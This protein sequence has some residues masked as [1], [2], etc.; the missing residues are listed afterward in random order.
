MNEKT[1]SQPSSSS[2][3]TVRNSWPEESSGTRE[4]SNNNYRGPKQE[5]IPDKDKWNLE[6][7]SITDKSLTHESS[8]GQRPSNDD[9]W[10]Q[11]STS[12]VGWGSRVPNEGP[13]PSNDNNWLQSSTAQEGWGHRVPNEG[14]RPSNDNNWST[15]QESWG[16]RV[17]NEGPRPSNDDNWLKSSTAQEGW[18]PRVHNE[19]DW[20]QASTSWETKPQVKDDWAKKQDPISNED[21]F[22]SNQVTDSKLEEN[23]E[24]KQSFIEDN[25][26]INDDDVIERSQ[27]PKDQEDNRVTKQGS[28][29]DDDDE[30]VTSGPPISSQVRENIIKQIPTPEDEWVTSQPST[31][32]HKDNQIIKQV[33]PQEEVEWVTSNPPTSFNDRDDQWKKQHFLHENN[34]WNK[35]RSAPSEDIRSHKKSDKDSWGGKGRS[36]GS[37]EKKNDVN[38]GSLK[39]AATRARSVD[40]HSK[41]FN[42]IDP[43]DMVE[44]DDLSEVIHNSFTTL[45]IKKH[46]ERKQFD[47]YDLNDNSNSAPPVTLQETDQTYLQDLILESNNKN[48]H[49]EQI[50]SSFTTNYQE[51]SGKTFHDVEVQTDPIDLTSLENYLN[52]IDPSIM[53][54]LRKELTSLLGIGSIRDI[55]NKLPTEVFSLK[56]TSSLSAIQTQN[57]LILDMEPNDINKFEPIKTYKP[58]T[59]SDTTFIKSQ[60]DF[61]TK[62][63]DPIVL[64]RDQNNT[65]TDEWKDT[66]TS[67]EWTSSAFQKDNKTFND[68][69]NNSTPKLPD[70][71][72]SKSQQE[73]SVKV[74][75]PSVIMRDQNNTKMDELKDT[76]SPLE[77]TPF[78]KDDK[79]FNEPW[80]NSTQKLP[81]ITFSK[82]QQDSSVKVNDLSIPARDQDNTKID[83]RRDIPSSHERTSHTF[84]KV[85]NG[86]WN[87]PSQKLSNNDSSGW[88]VQTDSITAKTT[89]SVK[90]LIE[91]DESKW[92]N[93]LNEPSQQALESWKVPHKKQVAKEEF[94]WNIPAKIPTQD[95]HKSVPESH[96]QPSHPITSIRRD[97][98]HDNSTD[99]TRRGGSSPRPFSNPMPP[100]FPPEEAWNKLLLADRGDDIE[101][102]KEAFEEYAKASPNE[103]FQTIEKKLRMEGC[104]G[105]I[106]ALK[107]EGIPL[108][109]CLI[110]LQ[111]NTNKKYLAQLITSPDRLSRA[112]GKASSEEENFQW[113][114][115]AGF[116]A[117][118]PTPVC[119]NCK[120]KG[121]KTNE[122]PEP[123]HENERNIPLACQHCGA[124]DHMTKL[125]KSDE[126]R[127]HYAEIRDQSI[128]SDRGY[129]YGPNNNMARDYNSDG[130]RSE[131]DY[132][133]RNFR[134]RG[135][136][137]HKCNRE[138]HISRDCPES[139]KDVR[140]CFKCGMTG[141]FERDCNIGNSYDG[142]GGGY[143]NDN[144]SSWK[145][146]STVQSNS[147][148]YNSKES[149][150]NKD[151]DY[152]APMR[153]TQDKNSD[154]LIDYDGNRS[155][156][157]GAKDEVNKSAS[158]VNNKKHDDE[159]KV[160]N[161]DDS[162]WLVTQN[163]ND[164]GVDDPWERAKKDA[165]AGWE[166]RPKVTT[167]AQV[168]TWD[169]P[170]NADF[171]NDVRPKL[172][173]Q[174]K[175]PAFGSSKV[176]APWGSQ[177]KAIN[178]NRPKWDTQ[179]K[180]SAFS[181]S[182]VDVPW[183][184]QEKATNYARPK[185]D[186]QGSTFSSSKGDAP[187]GSQ[188]KTT[189]DTRPTWGTHEKESTF[190]SSKV[191]APWGSQ[192]TNDTRP[193]WDT[194]EK[195]S[196]FSSSKVDPP[197]GSQTTNDA[198]P[199]WDAQG[200]TSSSSKD[201]VPRGSQANNDA[202]PKLDTQEIGSTFS[203]SK[204]DAQWGSQTTYDARPKWDMQEKVSTFSSSKV[205]APWGSQ[206]T[207]DTRP[208]WGTQEKGPTFSSKADAPW[209]SQTT[210]DIR[211]KWDAQGPTC[212]SSKIDPYEKG[213]SKFDTNDQS[214]FTQ[215]NYR[216]GT[217]S[218]SRDAE[219]RGP[220]SRERNN[221]IQH[222]Q[223]RNESDDKNDSWNKKDNINENNNQD[224]WK[225]AASNW[226]PNV[227]KPSVYSW[228]NQEQTIDKNSFN[229]DIDNSSNR[230]A[231]NSPHRSIAH[232]NESRGQSRSR[233]GDN[234]QEIPRDGGRHEFGRN[235]RETNDHETGFKNNDRGANRNR[236]FGLK[237][238]SGSS[239]KNNNGQENNWNNDNRW[240]NNEWE[241]NNRRSNNDRET[242]GH[243]YDRE[244]G[245]NWRNNNNHENS[246]NRRNNDRD[247]YNYTGRRN[248]GR[249]NWKNN[250]GNNF[251]E[252]GWKNEGEYNWNNNDRETT[253]WRGDDDRENNFRNDRETNWRN[254]DYRDDFRGRS[255]QPENLLRKGGSDK[256]E[257]PYDSRRANYQSSNSPRY[258]Q[259]P[260]NND[261]S[262]NHQGWGKK[263]DDAKPWW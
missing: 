78:Q 219:G 35:K 127:D 222:N 1:W 105:R 104:N 109:T 156:S 123:K 111:G 87:N 113:L 32:F 158:S 49:L 241:N 96:I 50:E 51:W 249:D 166:T 15:T 175:G 112:S 83:E 53:N 85:D 196:T 216:T 121:H 148:D 131:S 251:R 207:D 243:N 46:N 145:N 58:E 225:K 20:P 116:L 193:K 117:H 9:K 255:S 168:Y 231:Y 52:S 239:W 246:N 106:I 100:K 14:P 26:D 92:N 263:L 242:W 240:K 202:H 244:N 197:W 2:Y 230:G 98:S 30:W 25:D 6:R 118:D 75:D 195:G 142:F 24:Q 247:T 128:C 234:N 91:K 228:G 245:H 130:V 48:D 209:G 124:T 237:N 144:Y 89:V 135:L 223:V 176:N 157:L 61:S 199:K 262:S 97:S 191:N 146:P 211:P 119:F 220:Y 81:D 13:R 236:E 43:M 94:S 102:F 122:C 169:S 68:S 74:N 218:A 57:N 66:T 235:D 108:T 165:T 17:P 72:F 201:D 28:L 260:Q 155:T 233:Y 183:G 213:S 186:A 252:P 136:T 178:D 62:V 188:E 177:E 39:Y 190:D 101:E 80:N 149:S 56:D 161:N 182:K 200:S 69:W 16:S 31:P 8:W 70:T 214:S 132:D 27:T 34:S 189:N 37:W 22:V 152:Y 238:D 164:N 77:W 65:K 107:R 59:S 257:S 99:N 10:L 259:T 4:F 221:N 76:S 115:D 194:Q 227:Y 206:T 192:T 90:P 215:T 217:R 3:N 40:Q 86:S 7:P 261:Q 126:R 160:N 140:K 256:S 44:P 151:T 5:P 198:R 159:N 250:R 180:E 162:S 137:C 254:N 210:N 21:I 179:G 110:D 184:S 114:A 19:S 147:Q 33:P 45:Q 129:K 12:Q 229:K 205:D 88:S 171:N 248:S 103:T 173:V 185:W 181:S 41:N 11:S 167:G 258:N 212:S 153:N 208:K 47:E 82:T 232:S 125:C 23:L 95:S 150:R 79:T 73:S 172:D 84:Q 226:E 174:E 154:I 93:S 133:R 60:Q 64:T 253:R 139:K 170:V 224:E 204:V 120:H 54:F 163:Q 134:S 203:S 63:N 18:G 55:K 141:H 71:T 143:N 42:S 29:S 138:G 67:L 36:E 187:W 38:D